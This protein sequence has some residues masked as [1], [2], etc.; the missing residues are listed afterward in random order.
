M[1]RQI[2]NF[3]FPTNVFK[4]QVASSHGS[5]GFAHKV[6]ARKLWGENVGGSFHRHVLWTSPVSMV[7]IRIAYLGTGE[8]RVTSVSDR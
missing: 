1:M 6:T 5:R 7:D 4:S 8:R 3:S 2:P